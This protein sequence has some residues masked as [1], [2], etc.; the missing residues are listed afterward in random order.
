MQV[1]VRRVKGNASGSFFISATDGGD[2]LYKE[3]QY[4]CFPQNMPDAFARLPEKEI[5]DITSYMEVYTMSKCE[6]VRLTEDFQ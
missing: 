6:R 4:S 1:Q 2:I 3:V 5:N